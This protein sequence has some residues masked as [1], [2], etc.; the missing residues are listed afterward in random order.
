M[1]KALRRPKALGSLA[2]RGR[3]EEQGQ[4]QEEPQGLMNP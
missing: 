3:E 1:L 2:R 4:E